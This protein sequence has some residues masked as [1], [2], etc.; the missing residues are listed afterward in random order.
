MHG[1]GRT[2]DLDQVSW[3]GSQALG[4]RI[5]GS[6]N[7]VLLGRAI[8]LYEFALLLFLAQFVFRYKLVIARVNVQLRILPLLYNNILARL[9]ELG[10]GCNVIAVDFVYDQKHGYLLI[11]HSASTG[12]RLRL[13]NYQVTV[14]KTQSGPLSFFC[15]GKHARNH[16]LSATR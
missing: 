9:N 13:F 10:D 14:D 6:Y 8:L 3:S 15:V 16:S 5:K 2:V 12:L 4:L 11:E 7:R 1:G